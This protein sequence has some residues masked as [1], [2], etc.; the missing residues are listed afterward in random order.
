M[1]NYIKIFILFIIIISCNK[2]EIEPLTSEE[3]K[4]V[5]DLVISSCSKSI[6]IHDDFEYD[7]LIPTTDSQY[8]FTISKDILNLIRIV[9]PNNT[10]GSYQIKDTSEIKEDHHI[11]GYIN[12]DSFNCFTDNLIYVCYP[13]GNITITES[14]TSYVKGNLNVNVLNL[15]DTTNESINISGTFVLNQW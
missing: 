14:T 6:S 7:L 1:Y 5:K 15:N 8:S 13:T 12:A 11:T 4:S 9:V 2:Q 3:V 10:I